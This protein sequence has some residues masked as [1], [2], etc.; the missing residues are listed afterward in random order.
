M[1]ILYCTIP[2]FAAAL[3]RRDDERL[4][5]YPLALIGDRGQVFAVSGEAAACG[6]VAGLTARAAQIRCPEARLL[7]ANVVRYRD[8]SE[9]FLQILEHSSPQVEPHTWGAAYVDMGNLARSHAQAVSLCSDIGQAVRRELGNALQPALGWDSSKFTAQAAAQRTRPGHLLTIAAARE[10]TFLRPLPIP[11]LPLGEDALRRLGFLGLRT[12]GQY[13]ALPPAAVWQQFGQPG[14][15]AQR[16][17]R[18]EDDRPVIPRSQQRRLIADSEFE[19]PLAERER[20][21]AALQKLVS[22][23]LAQLRQDLQACGQIR[24]TVHFVDR[25]A[26]ER[27]RAFPIPTAKESKI[28]LALRRLLDGMHW[29]AEAQA[30]EVILERIQDAV[31]EQLSLFPAKNDK[32]RKLRQAKQALTA[33]LGANLLRRAVLPQPGAPLPEWRTGWVEA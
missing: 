18:G 4:R 15:I 24:L 11:L 17:A 31:A 14:R 26:Q 6:V 12:L 13:A 25:T 32:E 10:Q 5:D 7:E 8:E 33:R 20:L 3:A 30:L 1:S 16:C 28:L 27:E 22:P 9:A 29:P 2:Y 23:L 19:T 21:L